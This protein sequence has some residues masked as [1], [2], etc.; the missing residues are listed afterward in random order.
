VNPA[1]RAAA[2]AA[3]AS[4]ALLVT[5]G[6]TRGEQGAVIGSPHDLGAVT[7]GGGVSAC[8]L[9]HVP[10]DASGQLLYNG[11]PHAGDARFSGIAPSCYSCHDGTVSDR[12]LEV[13]DVALGQHPVQPGKAGQDC[14]RCHDPHLA[15]YGSFLKFP[16]GANLCKTCHAHSSSADHPVN[17]DAAPAGIVPLSTNWNPGAG[18][19]SGARLWDESGSKPGTYVKC[20]S[21]HGAH[22]AAAPA[23]LS[24]VADGRGSTALC[25][26]C[27]H[28]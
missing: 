12:G 28:R 19:F 6:L 5:L 23:L 7:G 16:T 11:D 17:V 4:M 9:C 24:V 18:D 21:C 3:A 25:A 15:D 20:L 2:M 26:N 1:L 8:E 22:G 13:F 27:H 14:D 10:G